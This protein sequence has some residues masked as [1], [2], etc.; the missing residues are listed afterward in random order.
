[1]TDVHDH[2]LA[3][4]GVVI[5]AHARIGHVPLTLSQ[6]LGCGL[7]VLDDQQEKGARN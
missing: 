1:V 6:G 2:S 5:R 4:V 7:A 3:G